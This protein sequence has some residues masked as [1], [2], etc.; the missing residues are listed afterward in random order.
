MKTIISN[1]VPD[2]YKSFTLEYPDD[3]YSYT[4]DF[5]GDF[6]KYKKS[7]LKCCGQQMLVVEIHGRNVDNVK[8]NNHV[9]RKT[10]KIKYNRICFC[11]SCEKYDEYFI[12]DYNTFN[13]VN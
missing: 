9:Y 8:C 4:K 11:N 7:I 5:E 6:L 13:R 2:K 3:Y 12:N 10:K 1:N